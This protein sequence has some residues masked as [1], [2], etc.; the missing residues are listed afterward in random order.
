M[1]TLYLVRHAIAADPG[2]AYAT[3][4]IRPL[5]DEG[6][7]RWKTQV[8]GLRQLDMV[9]DVILTSP[10]VRCR[11]TARWLGDGT[12]GGTI[13]V[14]DALRP[15]GRLDDVLEALAAYRQAASVAL[16]GHAPTIGELA[17]Q[18]VGAR[19]EFMFKK[20]AVCRID[21]LAI[22]PR[23]AGTLVWLLPPKAQRRLGE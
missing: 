17:A 21:V 23:T 11:E 10:Y 22:P 18:L 4:E 13:D 14:V 7:E 15:G 6:I 19:G 1:K 16:V 8:R 3:D 12:G 5:T 9:P 2:P 20:G